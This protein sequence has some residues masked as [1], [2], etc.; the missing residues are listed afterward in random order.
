MTSD[1]LMGAQGHSLASGVEEQ[2]QGLDIA[3]LLVARAHHRLDELSRCLEAALYPRR[4]VVPAVWLLL[5][6]AEGDEVSSICVDTE[7]LYN[8]L[9]A[10]VNERSE[11]D[12]LS[13]VQSELGQVVVKHAD[14]A[15]AMHHALANKVFA[16]EAEDVL[17]VLHEDAPLL[18]P[19]PVSAEKER[20][21]AARWR[22]SVWVF[23][24]HEDFNTEVAT[25]TSVLQE[26][27]GAPR[28]RVSLGPVAL[29]SSACVHTVQA[30]LNS[31]TPSRPPSPYVSLATPMTRDGQIFRLRP[32]PDQ[33]LKIRCVPNRGPVHYWVGLPEGVKIV[34]RVAQLACVAS[35]W[36]SKSAYRSVD[37]QVSFVEAGGQCATFD[38]TLLDHMPRE[39][40]D[41]KAP[42]QKNV[43]LSMQRYL[44]A[45]T[46]TAFPEAFTSCTRKTPKALFLHIADTHPH[47]PDAAEVQPSIP[48]PRE[49]PLHVFINV[50]PPTADIPSVTLHA[51]IRGSPYAGVSGLPRIMSYL[52][53]LHSLARLKRIVKH[54]GESSG[55]DDAVE[56]TACWT[57]TEVVRYWGKLDVRDTPES[58]FASDTI[59]DHPDSIEIKVSGQVTATRSQG[60]AS[61]IGLVDPKT[62]TRMQ[63]LV[64]LRIWDERSTQAIRTLASGDILCVTGVT[65]HTKKGRLSLM[66]QSLVGVEESAAVDSREVTV[67]ETTEA[68]L[69]AS[70]T[71]DEM[72]VVSKPANML[73]HPTS[74]MR[75]T[76]RPTASCEAARL[77]KLRQVYAIHTNE[78]DTS[79]LCFYSK[80][81]KLAESAAQS[82]KAARKQ[83]ILVAVA[84]EEPFISNLPTS[85]ESWECEEPLKE[86]VKEKDEKKAKKRRFANRV[87]CPAHTS[88]QCI[89]TSPQ[90]RAV[91]VLAEPHTTCTRQIRR[92]LAS[93]GLFIVGD[94]LQ[95]NG[96]TNRTFL[97]TYA[98]K[99]T[100]LHFLRA[101]F[102][103]DTTYTAPFPPALRT[104]FYSMPCDGS[105]VFKVEKG[106]EKEEG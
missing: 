72:V 32:T 50:S 20:D 35:I 48:N 33:E 10:D 40:A 47:L 82:I 103:N 92:H 104:L 31:P 66:A 102:P 106:E 26:T 14:V 99:E 54:Y 86:V 18:L 97:K 79:G 69:V 30:F 96:M 64:N 39:E 91:V 25:A 76:E 60:N 87:P 63:V 49:P 4:S 9:P 36:A 38:R 75:A 27:T 11:A 71:H 52:Q 95:G 88:F 19:H 94:H 46:C 42:N 55:G 28:V 1:A 12:I 56:E 58:T 57:A 17:I 5:L 70:F 77:L 45:H 85:G 22:R 80:S 6:S 3:F 81:S 84:V 44:A 101:T 34:D 53:S 7:K 16:V 74:T 2:G 41:G 67:V 23:G 98:Y 59:L 15:A 68:D 13:F 83:Y 62:C 8:A 78:K 93:R 90:A 89:T 43:S 65:C 29:Q 21:E 37:T 24:V 73:T 51:S 100:A 105:A 61:F